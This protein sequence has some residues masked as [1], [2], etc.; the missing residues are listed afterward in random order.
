[1]KSIL[2]A[3][4][5]VFIGLSAQANTSNKKDVKATTITKTVVT[6]NTYKT[7]TVGIYLDKNHKI[8]K[9]LSFVTK[10][11]KAKLA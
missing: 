2:T 7:S 4:L 11:S 10:A 8:K 3:L 5:F 6:F 9:E 1:M